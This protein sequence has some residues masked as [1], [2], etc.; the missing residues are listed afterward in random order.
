MN[1]LWEKKEI[2]GIR[3]IKKLMAFKAR[4]PVMKDR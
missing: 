3:G 2:R 1:W 4:Y